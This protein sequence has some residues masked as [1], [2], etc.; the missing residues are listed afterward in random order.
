MTLKSKALI[1]LDGFLN[2]EY[3]HKR[4]IIDLYEDVGEIFS[5]P[6][7][8]LDYLD[9]V[10]CGLSSSSLSLAIKNDFVSELIETY[11]NLGIKVITEFDS[12]YPNR[13]LDLPFNPL[14][15]Y[16]MGNVSLL[17]AKNTF[18]VVGSRK[19]LTEYLKITENIVSN[20]SKSGVTIVTGVAGGGDTA[21]IK[22]AIDSKNLIC[23]LASGF[24]FINGEI[25]Y[26]LIKKVIENGLL[27]SEYP[28]DIPP[29]N[30]RYPVRNRII[31]GLGDGTLIISGNEKSGTRH[32]ANYAIEYGKDVFCFPYQPNVES[33]KLCN[34]LIKDGAIL[35]TCL[36]DI[37][38]VLS[39]DAVANNKIALSS[40]EQTV[41][42]TIKN[43]IT[44]IDDIVENLSIK[45]F[46]LMPILT[47]LEIKGVIVKGSS[48]EYL[49]LK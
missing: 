42:D 3:K 30:F 6:K 44:K 17:N 28:P 41:Y 34:G 4:A 16:A 11:N 23:V 18:S 36:E 43:G 13:L 5:N 15:L 45:I 8:V 24:N 48:N 37:T 9:E 49:P 12:E 10:K 39:F 25:N 32:T 2:A 27:I 31:A 21:V 22:S 40:V 38:S 35:T 33:G 19:T 26:N 46:V 29:Q 7:I 20:L 1:L 47:S 14:C